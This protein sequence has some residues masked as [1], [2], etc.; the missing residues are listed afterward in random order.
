MYFLIEDD[1]LLQKFNLIV[2]LSII[3]KILKTKIRFHDNEVT[4]FYN[5]EIPRADS[6]YTCLVVISL[7]SALKKDE[8]YHQVFQ[9]EFK[10]IDKKVI[11]QI[12]Q[13]IEIF[14]NSPDEE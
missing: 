3:N 5:K 13:D 2:N 7:N 9:K 6:N 14:S 11:R 10:Y 1:D 12:T 8:D 4:D